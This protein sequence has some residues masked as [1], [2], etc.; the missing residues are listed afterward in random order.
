MPQVVAVSDLP[1]TKVNQRGRIGP[2]LPGELGT[3]FLR[4]HADA[5]DA[6]TAVL[7]RYENERYLQFARGVF[8]ADQEGDRLVREAGQ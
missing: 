3:T 5:P 1:P 8:R 2:G 4:A 7:T 6:P